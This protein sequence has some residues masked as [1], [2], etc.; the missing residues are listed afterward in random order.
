MALRNAILAA[1]GMM[2]VAY[3]YRQARPGSTG[4]AVVDIIL[5]KVAEPV[6][7]IMNGARGIRNNNPGNIVRTGERWQGMASDQSSDSRFVVFDSPVWGLRALARVMRSY[8]SQGRTTVAAIIGRWAPPNENNTQAYIAQVAAS[9][10][11]SPMTPLVLTDDVL[12]RIMEAIVKHEN[13]SQPYSPELFAQAI[14]LER[15]A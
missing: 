9:L 2:I 5:E 3:A 4:N 15:S 1:G 14:N 6:T 13:G 11:V 8:Y 10:G 12:S 7:M